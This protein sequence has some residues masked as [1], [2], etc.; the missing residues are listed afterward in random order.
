M[1]LNPQ[2]AVSYELSQLVPVVPIVNLA[3]RG[4]LELV[5][6]FQSSGSNLI[7]EHDL[8]EIFSRSY[9][10]AQFASTFKT[11]VQKS[12][13][14]KLAGIA[15]IVLEAGAGP[16]VQHAL[17]ETPFFSM[18]VQ[19][20]VLLW[21]HNVTSLA[22]T[23]S[24]SME[25]RATDRHQTFPSYQD[26]LGTLRS[27]QQQTSGFLWELYFSAVD[28]ILKSSLQ[29]HVGDISRAIP[30]AIL[31]TLID[32]LPAV[33]RFPENHFLLIR[34]S[35]GITALIVW[36]HHVL[37]LTVEIK[38]KTTIYKF[39]KDTASVSIDCSTEDSLL[40]AEVTLFNETLD[41]IFRATKD[42]LD[43]PILEP[44]CRHTLRGY[45]LR[46]LDYYGSD[47]A[48]AQK[49]VVLFTKSCL[50]L[51][52][53]KRNELRHNFSTINTN[54]KYVPSRER[55]LAVMR[56]LFPHYDIG[57]FDHKQP[58]PQNDA[59]CPFDAVPS[60]PRSKNDDQ[61]MNM[62]SK[63]RR[64]LTRLVFALAM[65]NNLDECGEVPL[66][67]YGLQQRMGLGYSV[68]TAQEAFTILASLLLD[69]F[70]EELQLDRA[71]VA[72]C[73]GWSLCISSILVE[74][75]AEIRADLSIKR[76]VPARNKERKEW[77]MDHPSG[78]LW[79]HTMDDKENL[80][81]ETVALPGDSDVLIK[82]FMDYSNV[83]YLVG[84]TDTSFQ[85]YTIFTCGHKPNSDAHVYA[86]LGFRYMQNIY[87]NT[88]SLP[89]C[90]HNVQKKEYLTIP[91]Y[92]SVFKG[93][94][95][96]LFLDTLEALLAAGK[97]R[98]E[99]ISQAATT[100]A[101]TQSQPSS[102]S[103]PK[104]LDTEASYTDKPTT[105][106]TAINQ[107]FPLDTQ[108]SEAAPDV[109]N[110][111]ITTTPWIHISLSANNVA[112]RWMLL[113]K[114]Q[115]LLQD[116]PEKLFE[117]CFL[118]SRHCCINCALQYIREEIGERPSPESALAMAGHRHIALIT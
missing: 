3:S 14:R 108:T 36:I 65:L 106:T 17:K 71:A 15:E 39:G 69:R 27:I 26:L 29:I 62:P 67:V 45:G 91:R 23:L 44:A 2:F 35:E 99:A 4:L 1:A 61:V 64:T 33:Q 93:L 42:P 84:T 9:I 49:F 95:D 113:A 89:Q 38:S 19:L 48:H 97:I 68:L 72:S 50:D 78:L 112:A 37:G 8:A 101:S 109:A 59:N 94:L 74:D 28:A 30:H 110:L 43:D 73:W 79:N 60:S 56:L 107:V 11:A 25:Y 55:I 88:C 66:K 52:E 63:S 16:T 58:Q 7:T 85:V 118:K 90:E 46:Y 18:V 41:V 76:G 6:D 40:L 13:I 47:N 104:A 114:V 12:K 20:S 117:A 53:A 83:R 81:Y 54:D 10:D 22:T 80:D 102:N 116:G 75:P 5:R 70:H 32:A 21:A 111:N 57:P 82:S 77:I 92:C 34:T 103:K 100:P 96:S 24:K 86:R 51:A 31:R 115:K 87:W 98:K 105:P